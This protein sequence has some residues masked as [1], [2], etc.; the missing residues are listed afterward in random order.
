MDSGAVMST[1]KV[2]WN[3]SID[4]EQKQIFDGLYTRKRKALRVINTVSIDEG[5]PSRSTVDPRYCFLETWNPIPR[6]TRIMHGIYY[7]LSA[8]ITT[9]LRKRMTPLIL[10]SSISSSNKPQSLLS[11]VPLMHATC[12]ERGMVYYTLICTGFD[13]NRPPKGKILTV[14]NWR[15]E[16][17]LLGKGR[18]SSFHEKWERSHTW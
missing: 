12:W 6:S 16:K 5:Y 18:R 3:M 14:D 8:P 2:K 9:W 11:S 10:A 13:T 15:S 7:K 17:L 1:L 4:G